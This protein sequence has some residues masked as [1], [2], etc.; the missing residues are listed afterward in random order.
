MQAMK[1]ILIV[2]QHGEN[3][4]DEAAMRAMLSRFQQELGKVEFTLLYQFRDRNLRLQFEEAVDDYPI[5]LPLTDYLRLLLF[6]CLKLV[7]I[8]LKWVLSP[9]LHSIIE[10]YEKTDLVVSAPGGPY[11]GDIYA[12][13][14]LI[15]WWFIWLGYIYQK[16]I[17]LYATSAGPFEN[18]LLN[19]VRRWLYPK[20]SKLVV[21]EEISANFIRRLLGQKTEIEITADSAIQVSLPPYSREQYFAGKSADLSNKFLVAVSLNNYLYP[22]ASD[23]EA[24]RETYNRVMIDL[25]YHL[26]KQRDCHLLLLPQLYGGFHSDIPFLEW[27]G[28][29]FSEE[30][31]WEVVNADLNSDIQRKLF[32][33]CDMH[34]ASRYHPVIFGNTGFVPGIC[35]YYEHKALGFMRQLGL[36]KYAFDIRNLDIKQ[37]CGAVD[38]MLAHKDA[39]VEHLKKAVPKL[40][41]RARKTTELAL[42]LL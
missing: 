21:R 33:M 30:V 29:K 18:R 27:I 34:I 40:Q 36:E 37:L 15:H 9:T 12:N 41:A 14:E 32:A 10:A 4:G 25:I 11:F 6:S 38:D 39:I 19:T 24:C 26:T 17:Y 3:R 20:F 2:N 42:S 16:P 7:G 28:N 31:S 13:H 8:D 23:S 35:I 1:H 22:G 5:V